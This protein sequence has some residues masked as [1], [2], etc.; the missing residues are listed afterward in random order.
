MKQNQYQSLESHAALRKTCEI[1][2]PYKFIPVDFQ[3]LV[4]ND[5]IPRACCHISDKNGRNEK[6]ERSRSCL[7][8]LLL[9]RRNLLKFCVNLQPIPLGHFHHKISTLGFPANSQYSVAFLQ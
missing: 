5:L 7:L 2:Y 1:L 4:M 6:Q 9:D 8:S 3:E